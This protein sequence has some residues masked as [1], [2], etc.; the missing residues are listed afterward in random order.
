MLELY[1]T[2][3]NERNGKEKLA[4]VL[5]KIDNWPLD[6]LDVE[7][8]KSIANENNNWRNSDFKNKNYIIEDLKIIRSIPFSQK[9]INGGNYVLNISRPVYSKDKKSCMFL[10]GISC[11]FGGGCLTENYGLI[12]ME[13]KKGMWVQVSN[14]KYQVYY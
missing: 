6:S 5:P 1:E 14:I 7:K 9:H 11:I 8:E 12:V 2:A 3:Y 13:K 10:Y 4:W